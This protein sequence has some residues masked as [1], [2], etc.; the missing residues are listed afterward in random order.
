MSRTDKLALLLSIVAI[1]AAWGVARKVFENIP[2]LEDELA[3]VWQAKLMA[4]GEATMPTPIE[5][6]KFLIPFV[7]DYNGLRFGKYPLGWPALLAVGIKLGVRDWVNPLLAG[8]A[9]WLMYVLGKRLMTEIVGFLAALLMVT[10]PFF[11]VNVGSLLSHAWGLVLSLGFVVAWWG[12]GEGGEGEKEKKGGGEGVKWVAA[13]TAGAALGMLAVTRP[14]SAVGVAIPFGLHG[15]Y[16]LVKGPGKV[17][18]RVILVGFLAGLV[19]L[20]VPLW[21]AVATG[22]PSLNPYTLWWSYDK[23]GF[24]PGH[25]V[26]PTGHTLRQG[27]INTKQ[28]L[29]VAA[30]DVFGWPWLSW[31]FLPFGVWASRRNGKVLLTGT[32]VVSLLV[33]YLAYWIGAWLFGPR[34]QF[35]GLYSLTLVS[36]AGIALLAGWLGSTRNLTME[37]G[38]TSEDTGDTAETGKNWRKVRKM[39]ITVLV[40]V[41]FAG[42]IF[43]YLPNRFHQMYGLYGISASR[44]APFLTPGVQKL[45]PAVIIVHGNIW[46]DYGNFL[47]L[48]DPLL[49]SP[50]IFTFG[51]SNSLKDS[52]L[53]TF[54]ER[55]IYHYYP[56]SEPYKFYT[57]RV[58]ELEP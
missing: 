26:I 5:P 34:Y 7:V 6:K 11:L 51:D 1:F 24:G 55:G 12:M 20:L 23:V 32:V 8:L 15:L 21:Q 39:G 45:A 25:G 2:H 22:D 10:S 31:L 38:H 42:N 14:F 41:L 58:P 44:L 46:S 19:S 28:L 30:S 53:E 47:D 54:P 33:L 36:A 18:G 57:G 4:A 50:F 9:V 48:E 37:S 43:F 17:R 29:G 27:W 52:L 35:E 3:Y 56:D 13:V 49:T 40:G 16:L